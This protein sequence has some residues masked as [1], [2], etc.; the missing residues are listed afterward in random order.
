MTSAI[1]GF[2]TQVSDA[3]SSSV[4]DKSISSVSTAPAITSVPHNYQIALPSSP[5]VSATPPRHGAPGEAIHTLFI[6]AL[7]GEV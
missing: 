3:R 4:A 2:M 6:N 1:S 5:L 7:P